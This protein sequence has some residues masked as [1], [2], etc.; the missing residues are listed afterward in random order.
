MLQIRYYDT[1]DHGVARVDN[2]N[3][4]AVKYMFVYNRQPYTKMEDRNWVFQGQL[5]PRNT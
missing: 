1:T 5:M 2:K 3:V 4:V